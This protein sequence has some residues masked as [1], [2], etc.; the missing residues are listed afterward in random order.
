MLDVTDAAR[1]EAV[2][3]EVARAH[4]RLSILVNN[5]GITR[6]GLAMRMKDDDWNAVLE[7][8]LSAS[9]GSAGAC[10]AG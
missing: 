3:D 7:T 1:C 8:N 6:D 9:F 2:V 5:A 4:G 10:C